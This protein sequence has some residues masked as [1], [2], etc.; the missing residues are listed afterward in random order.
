MG[1]IVISVHQVHSVLVRMRRNNEH[2]CCP[3]VQTSAV[4]ERAFDLDIVESLGKVV[5]DDD[6][7]CRHHYW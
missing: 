4:I 5:E 3:C 7:S 6:D 1:L 2:I